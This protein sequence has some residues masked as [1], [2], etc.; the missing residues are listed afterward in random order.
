MKR[1]ISLLMTTV[2]MFGICVSGTGCG[3]EESLHILTREEWIAQLADSFGLTQCYDCT[4]VYEDVDAENK[5]FNEIQACAEWEVIDKTKKFEPEKKADVNFAIETAVKMIGVERI[6]KSVDGESLKKSEDYID[7][8]NKNSDVKYI[9]GQSLYVDT[10]NTLLEYTQKLDSGIELVKS[11]NIETTEAVVETKANSVRFAA[12]GKTG[13]ILSGQYQVGDIISIEPCVQY[14]EGKYAKITSM[15]NNV[16][17]YD[18]PQLDEMYENLSV[19]GTYDLEVMGVVPLSDSV[20]VDAI[21][22]QKPEARVSDGQIIYANTSIQPTNVETDVSSQGIQ[23]S[24]SDGPIFGT[25]S[26]SNI[27]ATVGIDV[28]YGIVKEANITITDNIDAQLKVSGEA[29]KTFNMAKIP[30]RVSGVVGIDLVLTA[31]VNA[32]GEITL[33]L[34]VGTS[35]GISYKPLCVPKFHAQVTSCSKN[36][37][38]KADLS[39]TPMFRA[40]VVVGPFTVAN[41]G[42]YTGANAT[43]DITAYDDNGEKGTC[44]DL[45]GY[46]PLAV[47]VDDNGDTLLGSL[48]VKKTFTI[49]GESNSQLKFHYHWEELKQVEECTHTG[50]II[51]SEES[52]EESEQHE[53]SENE[54]IIVVNE[55]AIE[56][57]NTLGEYLSINS[58]YIVLDEGAAEQVTVSN[59]PEGYS[60][61]D[62]TF[63]S[64]NAQAVTV[65]TSGTVYAVDE[66]DAIIKI[67]SK[68]GKYTTYC[69]VHVIADYSVEFTPLQPIESIEQL[70]QGDIHYA[71]TI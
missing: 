35:E 30:C 27:K 32:S 1:W 70:R 37:E 13:R 67:Q 28:P 66:G 31:N 29:D 56:H 25:V 4:P 55:E 36:I 65:D 69:A 61:Q 71:I 5:Y 2:L 8:F 34:Q 58:M 40:D 9:S 45:S 43:A 20:Q 26:L 68:D 59:M 17:S 62:M 48:G 41:V 60:M 12:D 23:L 3:K 53:N 15:D 38:A 22:G 11:E 46:V 21:G 33:S 24:M 49:W 44:I 19:W 18:I 51:E 16:F 7:Y 52:A 63:R 39:F 10:A 64:S 54:D 42:A 57:I 50:D 14:P 6:A 47:F